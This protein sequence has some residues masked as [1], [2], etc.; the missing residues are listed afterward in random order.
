M[1]MMIIVIFIYLFLRNFSIFLTSMSIVTMLI[2]S[3]ARINIHPFR[4]ADSNESIASLI[5]LKISTSQIFRHMIALSIAKRKIY[6]I[7]DFLPGTPFLF[8]LNL[9]RSGRSELNY[10]LSTMNLINLVIMCLDI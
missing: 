10:K 7:C 4:H 9:E 3:S 2:R 1:I 8:Q 6:K 5:G